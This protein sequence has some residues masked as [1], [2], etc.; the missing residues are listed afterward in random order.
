MSRRLLALTLSLF[1]VPAAPAHATWSIVAVD[2][3]TR[4][5]GAAIASCIG[6]VDIAVKLVPATGV[7]VAQALANVEG[8]DRLAA[9]LTD[10]RS[11]SEALA[12]VATPEFDSTFGVPTVRLRQYGLV[13]LGFEDAP[14]QH[15]GAWT[16][17]WAGARADRGVAV[18]GNLL[19]RSAVVEDALAAFRAEPDGCRPTLADRLMTALE[20]GLR[21]GGDRRCSEDL[22][23][24][25]ALLVVSRPEDPVGSP[26]L[27]LMETHPRA[28]PLG[29]RAVWDEIRRN[30]IRPEAGT[31]RESPVTRLRE[32]YARALADRGEASC[33]PSAEPR[34]PDSAKTPAP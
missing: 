9:L 25:S 34:L 12:R 20:A 5:V 28:R 24:L 3:E 22:G 21:A 31:R 6:G 29:L 14:A 8:R 23:A 30:W 2:A 18:Q 27:R 26:A 16:F 1:A 7:V 33:A 10:G 17:G 4:E 15:T 19:W 11:P 13:G 32:A